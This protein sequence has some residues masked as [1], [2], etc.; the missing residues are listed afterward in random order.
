MIMSVGLLGLLIARYTPVFDVAGYLFWPLAKLLGL[1]EA[2]LISRAVA[3]GVTEMF[4][5]A[6]MV[7]GADLTARFVVAIVS[8][9]SILFFSASIPCIL[10]TEIPLT[11][12]EM[13]LIWIERTALSI[14]LA[15]AVAILVL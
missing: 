6:L 10:A 4:L 8:V 11:V 13:L 1:P 3:V 14:L 7:T 2:G 12:G 15:G 5:P 9:A